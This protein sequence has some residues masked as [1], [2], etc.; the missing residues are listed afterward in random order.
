MI[1]KNTKGAM[2]RKK[3]KALRWVVGALAALILISAAV[4]ALIG[5]NYYL[6]FKKDLPD[7][8]LLEDYRPSL[9]TK[10]YDD[11]GEIAGTFFIEKRILVPFDGIPKPLIEAFLSI[12]DARFYQHQGVDFQGISRAF[13]ENFRA[14]QITQG[15]STITQQLAKTLFLTPERTIQRKVREM[16][17][18]LDIEKRF[19]KE[20]I[21][22]LYLNQIYFGAGAYGVEAAADTYFGKH[23][24]ELSLGEMAVLA[25]LP[26]SP[27]HYDPFKHPESARMRRSLVLSRMAAEH[28]I[29]EGEKEEANAE[30][31]VLNNREKCSNEAAYFVEHVRRYLMDKFGSSRLYSSGLNVYTTLNMEMQAA[32]SKAVR[33]GLRDYDKRHGYRGPLGRLSPEEL[34]EVPAVLPSTRQTI[35]EKMICVDEILEGIVLAVNEEGAVVQVRSEEGFLPFEGMAWAKKAITGQRQKDYNPDTIDWREPKVPADVLAVGDR[36]LVKVMEYDPEAR[37]L[38]FALEQEPEVQGALIA[39]A[40]GTG[41]ITSMVGG[42]DFEKSEFNRTVQARRQPGSAFKPIIYGAAMERGFTPASVIIDTPVIF[43]EAD[44]DEKW[45][46]ANYSER[47]YGPTRLRVALA[48][49]RNVVTIKLLQKIGLD[50]V[51]DFAQRLGIKSPLTKDYSLA[52]GSSVVTLEELTS[53][54]GVFAQGG[55]RAEP[56]FIKKIL[57]YDGNVIEEHGPSLTQV[58]EPE[59]AFIVTDMMEDVVKYGTGKIMLKLGRP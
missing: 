18:A 28:F 3:R 26:K 19:T 43:E 10:V 11:A 42:Y 15:G 8:A 57:D 30:A 48:Q 13:W 51:T 12:E 41:A 31:L 16:L 14:Q 33:M 22:E 25:A 40:P 36:I 6:K 46:P 49:S 55:H 24:G 5:F 27:S 58:I 54:F 47:F 1:R 21:L 39:L 37:K 4:A 45:K 9:I 44:M 53:A 34:N 7:V 56:Y 23:V 52:L 35:E 2:P 20:E 32:A 29:T 38:V 17:L 59:V 50:S